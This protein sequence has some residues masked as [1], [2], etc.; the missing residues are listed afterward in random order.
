MSETRYLAVE[1]GG[2]KLQAALGDAAGTVFQTVRG[3][4]DVAAGA[5]GILAWIGDQVA[6]LL[7]EVGRDKVH[8]IGV[9]FGGP[10]DSRAG[11]V[12]VSHQIEGWNGFA[13]R[14]W[15][16][17]RFGLPTT[18]LN[19][20]SAAGWAEYR[21]GAGVG[22]RNFVYN[23]IG[24]GI[25]GL[26]EIEE[27][28]SKLFDRGPTRVSPFMIPKL[29]VNAATGNVSV[30]FGLKGPSSAVATAYLSTSACSSSSSSDSC[31]PQPTLHTRY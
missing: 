17:E 31:R 2:T 11:T 27:Q 15:F 22:T 23:N 4:V 1:I 24:S 5:E 20:S 30:Q 29:M 14:A 3:S 8:G 25:G 16:E 28:H 7:N 12:L 18:L 21:P 19:D 13:L 26:N 9:G 10:I 6:A